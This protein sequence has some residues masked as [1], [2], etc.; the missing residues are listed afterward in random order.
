VPRQPQPVAADLKA[1]YVDNCLRRLARVLADGRDAN[2]AALGRTWPR[3]ADEM[4]V[5]AALA[6]PVRVVVSLRGAA[7]VAERDLPGRMI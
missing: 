7:H 4:E 5:L 6:L 1:L 3:L 2:L